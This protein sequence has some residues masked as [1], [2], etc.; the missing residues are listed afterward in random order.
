MVTFT[1]HSYP[2]SVT[3]AT[4]GSPHD[5]DAHVPLVLRGAG[6]APGRVS[7]FVRTVD[8]GPTLAALLGVR[9]TEPL[10]GVVLREAIK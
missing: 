3:Y 1:P 10:D 7:R 8:L 6:I 9:P 2:A 5:G 4:H